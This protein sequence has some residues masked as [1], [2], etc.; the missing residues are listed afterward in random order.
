MLG[1]DAMNA[2]VT[3]QPGI[4]RVR[5]LDGRVAE[6]LGRVDGGQSLR[7]PHR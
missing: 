5:V 4:Q 2:A 3:P 6:E 7:V 1:P